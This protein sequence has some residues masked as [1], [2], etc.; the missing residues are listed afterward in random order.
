[1]QS[2][3][4]CVQMQLRAQLSHLAIAPKNEQI[5]DSRVI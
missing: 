4:F 5:G 1:M 2:N 3:L